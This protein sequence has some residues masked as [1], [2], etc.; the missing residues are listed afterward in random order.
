MKHLSRF[1]GLI[2]LVVV[3]TPLRAKAEITPQ[4][5]M[6]WS[7]QPSNVRWNVFYQNT[8]IN[9]VDDIN[10]YDPT[11]SEVYGITTM[12]VY[13]DTLI[14]KDIDMQIKRGCEFA[15]THEVGHCIA[16]A[17]HVYQWWAYRPEFVQI[18]QQERHNCVLLYQGEDDIREYFASAYDA[19]IRFPQILKRRCPST[20]NYISIVLQYT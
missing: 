1:I 17:N 8:N 19:Y 12:H 7:R 10:Y 2:L 9:V 14:V 5:M 13:P 4:L 11:L 3:L 6:E 15:L 20:Y 18:W 16:D